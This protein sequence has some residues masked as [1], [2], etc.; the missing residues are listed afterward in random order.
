MRCVC[1]TWLSFSTR[2][3]V[4]VLADSLSRLHAEKG[5]SVQTW[6]QVETR[7]GHELHK[8]QY[9]IDAAVRALCTPSSSSYDPVNASTRQL[10]NNDSCI[11][12]KAD[13]AESS[14]DWVA[15]AERQRQ[16][17]RQTQESRVQMMLAEARKRTT[18]TATADDTNAE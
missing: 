6:A 11:S 4:K 17:R 14:A 10:D 12:R 9:L 15:E 8:L 1:T 18:V 2:A 3:V 13:T 16:H 5:G 7:V